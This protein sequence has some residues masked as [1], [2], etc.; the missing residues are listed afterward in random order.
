MLIL[1]IRLDFVGYVSYYVLA[2]RFAKGNGKVY[3]YSLPR[4]STGAD[5]GRC[6]QAG[7]EAIHRAV[8]CHYFSPGLLL[9]A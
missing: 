2:G 5:P 7:D 4:V 1:P 6:V 3:L 8:G 9:P